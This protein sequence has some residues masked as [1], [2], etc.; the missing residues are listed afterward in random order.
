MPEPLHDPLPGTASRDAAAAGPEP[1]VRDKP[2]ADDEPA[3]PTDLRER[4][5]QQ[6]RHIQGLTGR[7][8]LRGGVDD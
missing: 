4:V 1:G 7:G 6:R 3:P 2:A 5:Q 8:P